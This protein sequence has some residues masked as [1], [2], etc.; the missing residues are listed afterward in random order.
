MEHRIRQIAFYGK[1]GIGKSTVASN[2][3]AAYA[4]RGL[5]TMLIGCDPKSDCTRNLRGDV[6]F[7][8][9]S[10]V[11]REK[12]AAKIELSELMSDKQIDIH[13]SIEEDGFVEML[14][15]LEAGTHVDMDEIV[16]KGHKGVFCVEA[17]GPEPA[18]G[19][20]GRGV[21]VTVDLL[22]RMGVYDGFDLDVIIYDV[23][24]DIVCGGLGMPLRK[25]LAHKVYIVTSAD[26]LSIYAANNICM[27]MKRHAKRGGAL[28]GGFIY[29]MRGTLDDVALVEEL[30]SIVG[31]KV[32]GALP[33]DPL[34][35]ES[36]IYAKTVI[37]YKPDSEIADQL[38]ELATMIFRDNECTIP[39][40]L[41][42]SEL[43]KWRTEIRG[44]TSGA[45]KT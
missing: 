6:D 10:E 24:G 23:L 15:E 29:N 33:N 7:P 19:C 2:I 40:P 4:E 34:I 9:V 12:G 32:V 35:S 22:K 20:A 5:N 30:A 8:T 16:Y 41:S 44:G 42:K 11:L 26:Y 13:Y 28:L 31:T 38:R 17:G 27:G 1:G 14:Y 36:E 39:E 37:E 25:G 3:A 21:I 45:L 18:V 43:A